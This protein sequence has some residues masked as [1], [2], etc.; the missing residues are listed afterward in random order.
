MRYP[1]FTVLKSGASYNR[2]EATAGPSSFGE[3]LL[4]KPHN[5]QVLTVLL[6]FGCGDSST[7]FDSLLLQIRTGEG[8][9]MILGAAAALCALLGFKVRTVCYSEYLSARD[10]KLF[11]EVFD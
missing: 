3:K 5:I 10:L 1:M 8:K 9:S 2:L 11:K 4:M 6:M 7:S